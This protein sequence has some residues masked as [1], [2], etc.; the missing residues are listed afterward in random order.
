MTNNTGSGLFAATFGIL[1]TAF[2]LILLTQGP[3]FLTASDPVDALT[4]A[5]GSFVYD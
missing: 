1:A 2:A 4:A 3:D 5:Y